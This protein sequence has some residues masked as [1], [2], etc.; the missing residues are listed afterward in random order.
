MS[1]EGHEDV[2]TRNGSQ[3]SCPF[4]NLRAAMRD[5]YYELALV[6]RRPTHLA[7]SKR[8]LCGYEML[9][10]QND[11]PITTFKG[12]PIRLDVMVPDDELWFMWDRTRLGRIWAIS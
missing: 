6:G 2:I 9:C 7:A 10:E 11:P 5:V 3:T 1:P 8:P 4:D 12:L